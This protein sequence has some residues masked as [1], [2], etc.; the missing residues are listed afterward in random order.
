VHCDL[1]PSNVLVSSDDRVVILDCGL[2]RDRP[3]GHQEPSGE[4]WGTAAYMSPEQ[5]LSPKVGPPSDWYSLGIMLYRVLTGRYPFEG[6]DGQILLDKQAAEPAPPSSIAPGVPADLDELCA[7]LLRRDPAARPGSTEIARRLG[8][9]KHRQPGWLAVDTAQATLDTV[10]VG[11]SDELSALRGC[12]QASR[13]EHVTVLIRGASGVGKTSLIRE[14]LARVSA[15]H[16]DALVLAGRCYQRESVPYRALDG[17]I[18]ALS[19]RLRRMDQIELAHMLPEG[20]GLLGRAFPVLLRV[21]AIAKLETRT[22]PA[23]DRQ[24][25]RARVFAAL[26][27][28]LVRLAD[29]SPVIVFVDD[30]QWTDADGLALLADVCHGPDAP[31]MSLLATVRTAPDAA[32]PPQLES[33]AAGLGRV[34]DLPL[35][36]LPPR[37]AEA[38]AA[39]LLQRLEPGLVASA[40]TIAANAAGHPLFIDELVRFHVDCPSEAVGR[41]TKLEEAI[42][43]RIRRLDDT[44]RELLAILAISEVPLR[45]ETASLAAGMSLDVA[46]RLLRMLTHEHL[47]R[48]APTADGATAVE[49]YHDRVREVLVGRLSEQ[50]RMWRH[51]R[52][53][54]ALYAAGAEVRAP[55]SLVRHLTLAGD[56]PRAARLAEQ[57]A[58]RA[59]EALAFEA[60][61][62]LYRAAIQMGDHSGEAVQSLRRGL[63]ECLVDAGRGPEAATVLEQIAASS[64]DSATRVDCLRRGAEQLMLTGHLDRG[65]SMLDTVAAECGLTLP[66]TARKALL[67][68][69][70]RRLK[71]RLRGY[72]WRARE[73]EAVPAR[74]LLE[75]DVYR[76]IGT[77]LT[78]VD[79]IRGQALLAQAS[80]LAL[81]SGVPERVLLTISTE[82]MLRAGVGDRERAVSLMDRAAVLAEQDGEPGAEAWLVGSLGGMKF[83]L[84]EFAEAVPLLERAIKAQA[85]LPPEERARVSTRGAYEAS[86]LRYWRMICLAFLGRC[87]EVRAE[88]YDCVRD[89]RRRGDRFAEANVV[90][91]LSLVW[92][93]EDDPDRV[94]RELAVELWTPPSDSLHIQHWMEMRSLALTHLYCGTGAQARAEIES[95]LRRLRGLQRLPIVAIRAEHEWLLGRLALAEAEAARAA[96]GEG[97]R[98]LRATL[99]AARRLVKLDRPHTLVTA[100]LLRGGVEHQRGN[101][102]PALEQLLRAEELA[103]R[104]GLGIMAAAARYRRGQLL[105]GTYGRQ[106]IDSVDGWARGEGIRCP[107]KLMR[108]YAPGFDAR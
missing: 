82:A 102:G 15:Y 19:D 99:A 32:L 97:R 59:S 20:A 106:L 27:Q 44:G 38:L 107:D 61:A 37:D 81:R 49:V 108:M 51:R 28:L 12:L 36:P 17:V 103:S 72:R 64:T 96:S 8:G 4:V 93:M 47:V 26:R 14:L 35:S 31:R 34:V 52:L 5:A 60:A 100:A 53:A 30:L 63:A 10:F 83:M 75:H 41:R 67:V 18:D 33:F 78:L 29:R 46:D 25:I 42:W 76:S 21:P 71:L 2:A 89:A 74:L 57:A 73:P 3:V 58:H 55:L 94:R 43:Q 7:A 24:Q 54:D 69:G 9:L 39:L 79:P 101:L 80:L 90:R 11:R 48:P 88:F 13:H 62:E 85:T 87:N 98:K 22:H 105:G 84:G 92:L 65:M 104:S 16:S 50:A 95:E 6:T 70:W 1:K 45:L 86:V 68:C 56:A 40:A 23:Q 66:S 77:I 91:G